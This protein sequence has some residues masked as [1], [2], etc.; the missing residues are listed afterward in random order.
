MKNSA[1]NPQCTAPRRPDEP[2]G[3]RPAN[4][5]SR[6]PERPQGFFAR[7][8]DLYVGGFREMTVG[9]RLWAI[10]LI[11]LA[12]IFL[13][14]KLFFFP[15]KLAEDYDND[16]DRAGAVRTALTGGEHH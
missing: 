2:V 12:I 10:I 9:R 11:K 5:D 7:V 6:S 3:E 14:F 1:D 13:V 4:R 8:R 15:D 16:R